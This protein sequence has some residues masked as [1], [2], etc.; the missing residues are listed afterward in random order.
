MTENL[1]P[2]K[3]IMRDPPD[4]ALSLYNRVLLVIAKHNFVR[5]RYYIPMVSSVMGDMKLIRAD[6]IM[7][8]EHGIVPI[9]LEDGWNQIIET[10]GQMTGKS[11]GPGEVRAFFPHHIQI[12]MTDAIHLVFELMKR[13][14]GYQ[15]PF[16]QT[17]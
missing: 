10:M 2:K 16:V 6:M 12:T 9:A 17:A 15:G 4:P 1:K 7:V 5:E 13:V 11:M 14:Y 3:L 8:G